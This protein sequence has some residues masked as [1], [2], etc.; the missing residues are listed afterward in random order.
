MWIEKITNFTKITNFSSVAHCI[1]TARPCKHAQ[2]MLYG[3]MGA[4][5]RPGNGLLLVVE[6]VL[7]PFGAPHGPRPSHRAWVENVHA[8]HSNAR[9]EQINGIKHTLMGLKHAF[10]A[11]R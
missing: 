11:L 5:A 8:K 6:G 4:N 1:V 3:N 10:N 2:C 9:Y 7:R